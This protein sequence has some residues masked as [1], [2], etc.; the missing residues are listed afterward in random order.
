MDIF[1][2]Q[3]IGLLQ[4]RLQIIIKDENEKHEFLMAF[5]I[6]VSFI[7]D[8]MNISYSQAATTKKRFKKVDE[9]VAKLC[10]S[11]LSNGK[12]WMHQFQITLF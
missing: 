11:P 6:L 4:R 12:K 10:P 2:Q 8:I 7:I 1:V 3:L 9:K 5:T